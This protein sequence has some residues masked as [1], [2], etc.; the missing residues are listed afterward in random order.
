MM[1]FLVSLELRYSKV[2]DWKRFRKIDQPWNLNSFFLKLI[3]DLSI[4]DLTKKI[5]IKIN[6]SFNWKNY[7]FPLFVLI[8]VGTHI[9]TFGTTIKKFYKL[10]QHSKFLQGL[11][12]PFKIIPQIHYNSMYWNIS[13]KQFPLE[14]IEVCQ[15]YKQSH[16][17]K[18]SMN[19]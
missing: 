1:L 12:M 14:F 9:L 3:L 10:N 7:F 18:Y 17:L 15:S 8:T 2:C 5:H 4:I 16:Y 11:D 13:M 19:L 6:T